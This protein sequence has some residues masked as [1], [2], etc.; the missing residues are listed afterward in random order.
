[1]RWSKAGIPDE[2]IRVQPPGFVLDNLFFPLWAG[3]TRWR[4]WHSFLVEVGQAVG[5]GTGVDAVSKFQNILA[6]RWLCMIPKPW[7]W[8]C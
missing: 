8:H 7:H 2:L 3:G 5:H 4:W 6:E 1:V